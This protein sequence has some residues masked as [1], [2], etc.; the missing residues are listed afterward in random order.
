MDTWHW[1]VSTRERVQ[2]IVKRVR[3]EGKVGTMA[4]WT[5]LI[6][7][8]LMSNVCVGQCSDATGAPG[9]PPLVSIENNT[10]LAALPSR[11]ARVFREGFA[12]AGDGGGAFYTLGSRPCL[13]GRGAGDGGAEV[14]LAGGG[15]ATIDWALVANQATPQLFEGAEHA[16]GD[17]AA[18]AAAFATGR[19]V[20]LPAGRYVSGPL[21]LTARHAGLVVRLDRDATIV[22]AASVNCS[23]FRLDGANNVTSKGEQSTATRVN[24]PPGREL[25]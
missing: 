1:A 2:G 6:L 25:H 15:C 17:T 23:L 22:L 8:A 4:K 19:E 14:P 10:A 16:S 7:L 20:R 12:Q 5:W 18:L 9:G 24:R 13:I 21:H 11:P 3:R